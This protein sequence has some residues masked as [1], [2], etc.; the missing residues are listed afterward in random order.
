LVMSGF[1]KYENHLS[2]LFKYS[3]LIGVNEGNEKDKLLIT[4]KLVSCVTLAI[5]TFVP[6]IISCIIPHWY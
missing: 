1:R 5:L 6:Y 3:Y 2:Y 4:L